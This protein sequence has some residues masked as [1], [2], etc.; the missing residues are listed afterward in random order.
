MNRAWRYACKDRDTE[1]SDV[2][3]GDVTTMEPLC[4]GH[5]STE[6]SVCSPHRAVYKSVSEL[7]TPL[8]TGQPA[9]SQ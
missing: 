3:W 1:W 8:Y 6:D 2:G 5:F 9:G 7:G 4:K